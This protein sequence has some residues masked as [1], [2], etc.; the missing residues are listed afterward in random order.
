MYVWIWNHLPG[1]APLRA[2]QSVLLA[3]L[4]AAALFVWVF[5]WVESQLPY[6]DVTVPGPASSTG[7]TGTPTELPAG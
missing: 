6:S 2:L 3:L 5:P 4:A 1:R 7:P